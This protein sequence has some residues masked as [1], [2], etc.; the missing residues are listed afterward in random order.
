MSQKLQYLRNVFHFFP[1]NESETFIF[2]FF[3]NLHYT[4]SETFQVFFWFCFNPDDY[5]LQ[6]M[7]I[8]NPVARNIRIKVRYF[9]SESKNFRLL[10]HDHG[11]DWSLLKG[12]A[13]HRVAVS[14]HIYE[15]LTGKEKP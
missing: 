6:F 4:Q 12:L 9:L 14:K 11:E 7:E 2:Y 5:G 13:V 8:I 3:F 15:M 10:P 1:Q